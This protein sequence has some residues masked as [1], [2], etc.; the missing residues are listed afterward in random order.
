MGK[1][2]VPKIETISKHRFD[3]GSAAK[4][5]FSLTVFV[6]ALGEEPNC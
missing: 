4:K 6:A 1:V 5:L 3:Y 2:L